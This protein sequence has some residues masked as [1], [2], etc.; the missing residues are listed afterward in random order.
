[1]KLS[2]HLSRFQEGVAQLLKAENVT[3]G[4]AKIARP[5]V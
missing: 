1:M 5:E 3:K 2:I 4:W